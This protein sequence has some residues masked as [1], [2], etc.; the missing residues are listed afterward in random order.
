LLDGITSSSFI[1]TGASNQGDY[2]IASSTDDQNG[3]PYASIELRESNF[4]GSAAYTAPRLSFHWGGV[5]ASQISIE[6]GGRI[7]I[8]DNPG[9]GYEDL[10]ADQMIARQFL[11]GDNEAYYADPA[12]TSLLSVVQSDTYKDSGGTTRTSYSGGNVVVTVG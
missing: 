11:D 3:Y 6:S 5:V 4:G 12:G 2:Q 8:V 9:T 7:V 10:R 1:Y